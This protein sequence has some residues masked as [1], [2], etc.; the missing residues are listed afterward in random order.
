[1]RLRA[2]VPIEAIA[3]VFAQDGLVPG[4]VI[5]MQGLRWMENGLLPGIVAVE[6]ADGGGL[7]PNVPVLKRPGVN[8]YLP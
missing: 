5:R 2:L 3:F 7:I 6:E 8:G 4:F 1:M